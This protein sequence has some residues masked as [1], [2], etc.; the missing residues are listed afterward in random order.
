MNNFKGQITN[1]FNLKAP[2]GETWHVGVNKIADEMYLMSGWDDFAKA[3]ELKEND[4]L[5]F[6]CSGNSSFEVLIF[7]ASGCE[8][9]SSLFADKTG[10]KMRKHLDNMV[11]QQVEQYC[12]S[13]SDDTSTPSQLVG[14]P[15][16]ASTSKKFSGKTKQ[17]GR[18]SWRS[19]LTHTP[20]TMHHQE[21]VFL[22][23]FQYM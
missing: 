7:D 10:S 13:D 8:K 1:G 22:Y 15:H 16:K 21:C 11:G 19:Q 18:R 14:S 20:E 12:L 23:H 17:K 3:H 2:S 4:L 9:L 6:T 5:L